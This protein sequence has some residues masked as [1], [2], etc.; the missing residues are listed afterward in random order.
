MFNQDKKDDDD[1]VEKQSKDDPNINKLDVRSLREFWRNRI[2]ES[3]HDQH[4]SDRD[5][6]GGFEM[7]SFEVESCLKWSCVNCFN[8]YN[9]YYLSND[10]DAQWRQEYS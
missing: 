1:K 3:V 6:D 2:V 7:F 9:Q 10:D 5:G 4:C 8:A